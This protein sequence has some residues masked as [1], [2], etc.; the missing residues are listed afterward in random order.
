MGLSS[1]T[2]AGDLIC[3]LTSEAADPEKE[4]AEVE[5]LETWPPAPL[6]GCPVSDLKHTEGYKPTSQA[7]VGQLTWDLLERTPATNPLIT[8]LKGGG[9]AAEG[10]SKETEGGGTSAVERERTMRN[11]VDV[12]R[13]VERRHRRDRERQMLRVRGERVVFWSFPLTAQPHLQV[14][15]R[16]TIVQSRKAEEDLLG[17]RRADGLTRATQNL[18]EVTRFTRTPENGRWLD[19]SIKTP[20]SGG[21][22]PTAICRQRAR[23][24]AEKR[25]LVCGAVQTGQVTRTLASTTRLTTTVKLFLLFFLC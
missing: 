7:S 13:K 2:H 8:V 6:P 5:R 1:E 19:M 11:L 10:Q 23:G 16:L 20:V 14:Q 3:G 9:S 18:P 22:A 15:E 4:Q 17:R 24:A 25:A 21:Q 12:Q